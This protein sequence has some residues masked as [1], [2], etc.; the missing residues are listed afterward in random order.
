MR[1]VLATIVP[2]VI[3]LAG[4]LAGVA[5]GAKLNFDSGHRTWVL[6]NKKSEWRELF[7]AVQ[8]A[9]IRM[10]DAISTE[11]A[12]DLAKSVQRVFVVLNNRMFIA[13]TV[14][15]EKLVDRWDRINRYVNR[16]TVP[17]YRPNEQDMLSFEHE[18]KTFPEH[19]IA[20]SRKDLRI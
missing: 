3:G 11:S 5:L 18:R 10:A 12:D 8:Q 1:E 13:D 4:G 14:A 2:A 9:L 19:L 16:V 20:L 6:D 17:T 7:D 15:R